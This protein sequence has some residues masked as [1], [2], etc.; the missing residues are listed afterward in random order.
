MKFA[1]AFALAALASACVPQK[2]PEKIGPYPG[3]Y[4]QA[5]AAD[6]K[7]RF[8]DPYSLRDVAISEPH[9]GYLLM[10]Q[11]WVVCVRA[12]GKNRMGAYVGMKD[13][14]FLVNNGKVIAASDDFPACSNL[15][16]TPWPELD[17]GPKPR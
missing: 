14:G 10:Q 2:D 1:W 3:N 11:G 8:F 5:V 6:I 4:K 13:T 12:N 7:T 16:F 9:E 17:S 15:K